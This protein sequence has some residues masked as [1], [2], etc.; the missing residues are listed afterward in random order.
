MVAASSGWAWRIRSKVL[1]AS[2]GNIVSPSAYTSAERGR[3]SSSHISPKATPGA[4]EATR[5]R[6]SSSG[7]LQRL[8]EDGQVVAAQSPAE[9]GFVIGQSRNPRTRAAPGVVRAARHASRARQAAEAG[10]DN[11]GR[12]LGQQ[13]AVGGLAARQHAVDRRHGEQSLQGGEQGQAQCREQQARDRGQHF[14]IVEGPGKAAQDIEVRQFRHYGNKGAAECRGCEDE[15]QRVGQHRA[16][17]DGHQQRRNVGGKAR[18]LQGDQ[19]GDHAHCQR[20][21]RRRR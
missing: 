19:Q 15:R 16:G 5:L 7:F 6:P 9:L 4:S 3:P 17:N 12:A 18:R 10:R 8:V 20:D 1:R 13:L 21:G 2:F 14:R 11:I